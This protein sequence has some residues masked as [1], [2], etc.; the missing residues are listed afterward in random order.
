MGL[1]QTEQME[2][3]VLDRQRHRNMVLKQNE[4]TKGRL[5]PRPNRPKYGY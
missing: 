4:Q 1:D 5:W 2:I 3:E